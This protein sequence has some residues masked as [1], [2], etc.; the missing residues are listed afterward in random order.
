MKSTLFGI[1]CYL[2]VGV[3]VA[4][5]DASTDFIP[6]FDGKTLNGWTATVE[7]ANTFLVEDG[8]LICR[9]GRAHLFYTGNVG[10]ADFKNFELKLKVKTNANSNSGVYFH[11]KYQKE[12]WPAVGF[13]AQVNSRHTD[14]RKTGSLYGIVNVWAPAEKEEPYLAK[15]DKSGEIF[16]L[17]SKAPSKDGKWFD[18]HI[19]VQDNTIII[20]VNGK[21]TV[22][23]TQPENWTK[24]RKIGRG[25]VGLQA[26][27]PTCDVYYKDI[28]IKIL[29]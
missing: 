7:N 3:A 26:H 18:Y 10:N 12:G 15:V 23:W 11:T 2:F 1:I 22:H 21:T 13:E 17:Q 25:T 20:K 9:G 8:N 28:K 5:N 16:M 29:D 4:Q 6:L 24:D 14:P 27:D 19:T